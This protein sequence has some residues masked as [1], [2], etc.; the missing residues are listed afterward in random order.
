[1]KE[2]Y[3]DDPY[4]KDIYEARES[5][6]SRDRIPWIEYMLQEGLLFKCSQSCIPKCSMRDKLLQEKNGR[7]L[8]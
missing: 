5:L 7:G 2:M 4:F 3:N 1:M 6:V 8:A